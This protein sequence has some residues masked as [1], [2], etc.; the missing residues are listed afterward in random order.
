MVALVQTASTLP[1]FLLG[2]PSGAFA[3]IL[4]RRRYFM[5][6]QFWVAGVAIVLCVASLGG[7]LSASLLLLLTFANGIG[8]A[9]RWPV[10][11]AIV[12]ELV[13]RGQLPAALAL[14]GIAMNVS[15]IIGPVIAGALLAAAGSAYV[16]LLNAVLSLASAFVIMR[17]RSA[18]KAQRAA[19]RALPRR[20]PRRA[21]IRRA[22]A[23]HA[24]R[25]VARRRCSFCS[26]PRC[27][28]CF[29]WSPR[30]FTKAM[31]AHSHCCW[32]RWAPAR[33]WPR[34]RCRGCGRS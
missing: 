32:P 22:V 19:G 25:V 23:A 13:P 18:Q 30:L 15:R 8:L 29:R 1:V 10:F 2:V 6:T 9:M 12:P 4:D 20:D 5:A 21:A 16:F 33:S 14:N 3:D 27:L 24:R 28:H 11:A 34:S 31:Q 17:W 7:V 26:R